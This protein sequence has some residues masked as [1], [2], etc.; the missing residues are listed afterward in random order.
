MEIK[1][2]AYAHS[3]YI[4]NKIK[5][6]CNEYGKTFVDQEGLSFKIVG[7]ELNE[8]V[9]ILADEK[10]ANTEEFFSEQ[11]KNHVKSSKSKSTITTI[12][13]L[14]IVFIIGYFIVKSCSNTTDDDITLNCKVSNSGT[15]II[16]MN[17]DIFNWT[18]VEITLNDDFV[19]KTAIISSNSD[20]KI[21]LLLFADGS[22][23]KFN[24]FDYKVQKVQISCRVDEKYGF[25]LGDFK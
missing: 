7:D 16:I 1:L 13:L 24:P 25:W 20:I 10:L 18:D 12:V 22:G 17:S 14:V 6:R 5:E 4:K 8:L 19:Y 2:K 21:G 3:D 23:K 9:K 15:Q 11:V